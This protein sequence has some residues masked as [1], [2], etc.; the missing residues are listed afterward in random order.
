MTEGMTNP[1]YFDLRDEDGRREIDLETYVM[2]EVLA[3][4]GAVK[5]KAEIS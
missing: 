3:E 5:V 2:S 1:N 4:P